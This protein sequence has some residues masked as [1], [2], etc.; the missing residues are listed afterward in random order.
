VRAQTCAAALSLVWAAAAVARTNQTRAADRRKKG[1]KRLFCPLSLS[2]PRRPSPPPDRLTSLA[3]G[4]RVTPGL[5]S[6]ATSSDGWDANAIAFWWGEG[7][8]PL[9]F[10]SFGLKNSSRGTSPLYA[11]ARVCPRPLRGG[12]CS[13]NAGCGGRGAVRFGSSFSFRSLVR[14]VYEGEKK[15]GRK[16]EEE[17]R[18]KK[19]CS[20]LLS[21]LDARAS[22][23][24]QTQNR[25]GA[26]AP[27]E[28]YTSALFRI[29]I[30]PLFRAT[31]NMSSRGAED[32]H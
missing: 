10:S 25:E 13:F 7:E 11:R 32:Q 3:Q 18:R 29:N 21:L 2:P 1:Q 24:P 28:R 16:G 6:A 15:E 9:P 27:N 31:E 4:W 8:A 23:Q 17:K 5:P 30:P 12:Y 19:G 20:W 26:R 22:R 14:F